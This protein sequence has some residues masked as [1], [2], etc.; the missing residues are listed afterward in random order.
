M[1]FAH[2]FTLILL[3]FKFGGLFAA[4]VKDYDD[5][6]IELHDQRQNGTENYRLDMK[7]VVIVFSPLETMFSIAGEAGILK[8]PQ[9]ASSDLGQLAFLADFKHLDNNAP[10]IGHSSYQSTKP[11]KKW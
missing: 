9:Q 2:N 10:E 4:P 6:N 8:P 7:D 11:I 1:T 3:V 5:P